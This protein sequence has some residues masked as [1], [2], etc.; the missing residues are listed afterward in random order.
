MNERFCCDGRCAENQGRGTCPRIDKQP[1]SDP[2][3]NAV[4]IDIL[5]V[6]ALLLFV[7]GVAAYGEAVRAWILS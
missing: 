5:C 3:I 6:L 7:W 2:G 1:K 4:V